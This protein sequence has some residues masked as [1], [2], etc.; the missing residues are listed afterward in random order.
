MLSNLV[1]KTKKDYY[2]AKFSSLSGDKKRVWKLIN[3]LRGKC[4][5]SLPSI[6]RIG[7]SEASCHKKIQTRSTSISLH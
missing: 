7:D 6:F 3:S 5:K 4:N 1:K 2:K